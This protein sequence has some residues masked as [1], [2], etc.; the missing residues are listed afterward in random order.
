MAIRTPIA[1]AYWLMKLNTTPIEEPMYCIQFA[2]FSARLCCGAMPY[3]SSL[4]WRE[5]IE[6]AKVLSPL[7]A[8]EPRLSSQ[9]WF[10]GDS[11]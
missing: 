3:L 6:G 2:V 8:R 11:D 1:A 10:V 5:H 4:S 7:V 9:G